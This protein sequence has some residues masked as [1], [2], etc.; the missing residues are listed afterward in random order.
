LSS[1]DSGHGHE[2][3]AG[4]ACRRACPIFCDDHRIALTSGWRIDSQE[5]AQIFPDSAIRLAGKT[6]L[7][8]W[9]TLLMVL[10]GEAG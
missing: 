9:W 4:V 2:G 6:V 10:A 7:L 3:K 5:D 8:R 1:V